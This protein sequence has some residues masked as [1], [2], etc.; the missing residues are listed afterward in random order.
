MFAATSISCLTVS[1]PRLLFDVPECDTDEEANPGGHLGFYCSHAY[2]H[3]GSEAVIVPDM[4]KGLDMMVLEAF[5][6]LKIEASVKP[7]MEV[8]DS[9]ERNR[10]YIGREPGERMENLG[11]M[12][13]EDGIDELIEEW[14]EGEKLDWEQ[15]HWVNEPRHKQVQMSYIA[16]SSNLLIHPLFVLQNLVTL[17]LMNSV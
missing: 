8:E 17:I 13:M 9:Y 10:M 1:F 16:V 6:R 5:R 12:G 14:R 3:T 11:S 15:V 2:P 4:L 7:V